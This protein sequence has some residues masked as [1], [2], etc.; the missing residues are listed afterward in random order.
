MSR[1][2]KNKPKEGQNMRVALK[3]VLLSTCAVFALGAQKVDLK[4][5]QKEIQTLQAQVNE[6]KEQQASTIQAQQKQIDELYDRA[7]QNEFAATLNKV[8]MGLEMTTGVTSSNIKYRSATP[9]ET[10][11]KLISGKDA[12]MKKHSSDGRWSTEVHLNLNANINDRTR[13][14][15]RLAMAKYWGSYGP[16]FGINDFE[17][18][19]DLRG[20]S[21]VYLDRAYLDYEIIPGTLIATIGRQPGTDGPGSNL[22]NNSARMSTYPALLVNAMGDA[23][24]LTYKPEALKDFNVALRIAYITFYQNIGFSDVSRHT[25]ERGIGDNSRL[26]F[27][28]AEGELPLGSFGKN[29][30]MLSYIH[31]DKFMAPMK[32]S[33]LGAAILDRDYNVGNADA[34]NLHFESTNTFGSPLSW[35]ASFGYWK[36][37]KARDNSAE[38]K[39]E[40]DPVLTAA[41]MLDP[42]ILAAKENIENMIIENTKWNEKSGWAVHLGAR[43]DF[44]KAF[45]LGMEF[46]H[47]SKYWY[48][49]GRSSIN[50]P[51][52]FRNTRGNVYDI[53]AIWQL[54]LNQYLRLSYTHIDYQY[55]NSSKPVGGAV[56]TDDKANIFSLIYNVRF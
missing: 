49:I 3:A 44:T 46:L 55:T 5:L 27:A 52:D 19:K 25:A 7:D 8:K 36:G 17:A 43:Y 31:G 47:G 26:Y 56:K 39:A 12:P 1:F 18:G 9:N 38:M 54:D 24:V 33:F 28:M 51:F 22:R 23:A 40:M 53:Y 16:D 15:G 2:K 50:D 37:S 42:R 29:V 6:L 10:Y 41:G 34:I 35:F 11:S 30:L 45:K 14:T 48:A 21:S 4:E 20:G 32:R 13:F